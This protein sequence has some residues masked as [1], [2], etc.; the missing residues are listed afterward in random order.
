MI[1]ELHL[2]YCQTFLLSVL[3][4]TFI[5]HRYHIRLLTIVTCN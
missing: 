4:K 1:D 2:Y 3:V 5:R